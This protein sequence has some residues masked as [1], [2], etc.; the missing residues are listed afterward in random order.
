MQGL[1][2]IGKTTRDV[3]FKTC[4]FIY[5]GIPVILS[6]WDAKV[7]DVDETEKAFHEDKR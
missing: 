5:N 2:K 1:V 6:I 7:K 3:F 4:R